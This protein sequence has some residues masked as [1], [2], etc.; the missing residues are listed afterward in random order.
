MNQADIMV[1]GGVL[2]SFSCV[3]RSNPGPS[4]HRHREPPILQISESGGCLSCSR[5]PIRPKTSFPGLEEG[6]N[7]F[8]SAN[9]DCLHVK[10]SQ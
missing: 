6:N 5:K 8:S 10:R 3:R 7:R 2:L 9:I 4:R 1:V